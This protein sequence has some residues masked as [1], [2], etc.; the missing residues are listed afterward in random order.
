MLIRYF[1]SKTII[2]QRLTNGTSHIPGPEISKWTGVIYTYYWMKGSA[3]MYI[4]QLHEEYGPIVRVCP[5]MVDICDTAAVKEIHKTNSRFLKTVWYRNLVNNSVHNVFSTVDPKFHAVHRRL[6]ASP[7]SDSSITRFEPLIADRINLTISRMKQEIESRG[8]ADVFKWWLFMATDIIGELSFGDSFRMLEA[9]KKNQYI[10]DMERLASYAAIRTSFPR[11]MKLAGYAP[12]PMIQEGIQA[13]KRL[14]MYAAQSVDRYRSLIAENPS[15]PKPTLL[16]K[17]FDTEKN[18]LTYEDI[19]Q[20]A[21]GFIVAGSDTTAVTMTYLS[22][23]VSNDSRVREKLVAELMGIPEPVRDKDLRYLPYLNNVI[24]E[25][26]RLYTAVPFGLP[27]AVPTEGAE[28]CGYSLPGG[29][30]VSTQSHSLHRD[31]SIFSDPDSFNPERWETPT[32]EMKDA[33]LPFGGGSRIC[34]G[35]HLARMELR[36]ATALFFRAL[37]DARP[38]KKEGM[39]E[40][41]MI[42]ESFFLMAPQG[43][44]CL[45]ET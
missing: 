45:I 35:I 7:I 2:Y 18:G 8:V 42:M 11:L 38:S 6:L 15:D 17:L 25:S 14:R 10:M 16:T 41:D 9:G 26:L 29:I 1:V 5:D 19:R 44:R 4:H 40:N 24:T 22:Y 36:L 30:T 20:E 39:S 23:A 13:G 37:P 34:L 33:S 28:F 27:R 43:H 12:L 21:Q 31:P 32:K 3:P